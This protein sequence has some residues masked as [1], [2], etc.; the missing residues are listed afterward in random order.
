M[1]RYR[2]NKLLIV[3][4]VFVLALWIYVSR[5]NDKISKRQYNVMVW[6]SPYKKHHIDYHRKCGQI[7]CRFSS[8]REASKDDYFMG[9]LFDGA[10]ITLNDLPKTRKY[11]EYWAL[12]YDSSPKDVPFLLQSIHLFNFT[13]SFSRYS[14]IPL[15]LQPFTSLEELI[16]YKLMYTYGQKSA[17]QKNIKL[18]PILYLQSHCNTLTGR[19]LY[20]Q[21]LGRHIAIDSYGACLKNKSLPANIEDDATNPRD[22]RNFYDF[23]SKYKFMIVYEDVACE[24]YISSKFWKSLTLGVVPIYFGATNIRN[25]LPNPGSAILVED[26]AKPADLAQ[27]IQKVSNS[28]ESYTSFLLHKTVDFYPITN[29]PLVDYLFRQDIQYVENRKARTI[30]EFECYVCA[31]SSAGL[32]KQAAEREFTCKLPHFPPGNVTHKAMPRVQSFIEQVRAEAAEV[33]KMIEFIG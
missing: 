18:A 13:S 29:Q 9:Y 7:E 21:Q 11:D 30:A 12:Y 20:V 22:I 5:K 24:D 1:G 16:N 2:N 14:D 6:W 4:A 28:E 33:E 31:Q 17:F 3:A 23:V 26:F 8:D 15:T 19:E 32:Q 25:Y 10:K 27:F